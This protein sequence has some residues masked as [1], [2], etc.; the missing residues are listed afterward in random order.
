MVAT[1]GEVT[2]L[3]VALSAG[4][5][6]VQEALAP[7]V[8]AELKRIARGR[9][10]RESASQ[11]LQTTALVHEAWLSL[12]DQQRV[13]WQGR[14]HFFAV[15]S[16]AMR[17]VLVDQARA[18]RRLK[19]GG[20]TVIVSLEAVGEPGAAPRTLDILA[21][22][23]ALQRLEEQSVRARKVVECRYFGGL[24]ID[25]TAEALGVAPMTVK[26]DWRTARAWLARALSQESEPE[27]R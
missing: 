24:S 5:S 9:L 12:V 14:A 22:D 18:R 3:L 4:R 1:R 20:D 10:R 19:R 8:Y 17:R 15:A 23:R 2:E 16:M 21:L 25:E 27:H 6:G 26:R 7:L 13:Q 11:P